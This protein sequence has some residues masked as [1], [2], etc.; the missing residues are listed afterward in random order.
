[1][2]SNSLEAQLT[3]T[4]ARYSR[5][6]TIGPRSMMRQRRGRETISIERGPHPVGTMLHLLLRHDENRAPAR[7]PANPL[8]TA[9]NHRVARKA[10]A[11]QYLIPFFLSFFVSP[12]S[13]LHPFFFHWPLYSFLYSIPSTNSRGNPFSYSSYFTITISG[14]SRFS[15]PYRTLFSLLL[16]I[17][18]LRE[19]TR[20][21][22]HIWSSRGLI[23]S[24]LWGAQPILT[25]SYDCFR[26]SFIFMN[27]SIVYYHTLLNLP[28]FAFIK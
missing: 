2:L 28:R 14:S 23:G 6:K 18:A 8:E 17:S 16:N 22:T 26:N 20:A 9:K 7:T 12:F 15:S 4:D 5:S 3:K 13:S 24:F 11:R 21:S 19:R 27:P 25:T 10:A 1:M